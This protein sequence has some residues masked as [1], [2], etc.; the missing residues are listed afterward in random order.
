VNIQDKVKEAAGSVDLEYE[1]FKKDFSGAGR[2]GAEEARSRIS[3]ALDSYSGAI[4]SLPYS[5]ESQAHRRLCAALEA[6]NSAE[7]E[8]GGELD[9]AA[10]MNYCIPF[11][12]LKEWLASK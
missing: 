10:L 4:A 6:A 11:S 2:K 3:R 12:D 9:S 5:E 8:Q 7:L 1:Q